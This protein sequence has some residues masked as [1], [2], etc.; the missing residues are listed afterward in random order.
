MGELTKAQLFALQAID[1]GRGDYASQLGQAMMERPGVE[2]KRRGGNR[3]SPQG[4]GRVGG[5]MIAR[6]ERM[7]LVLHMCR[8][9]R[10]GSYTRLTP[11]GRAILT[12][13]GE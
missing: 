1:K 3:T 5:T 13:K 2:E 9:E 4:L 12:Q 8:T 11:A 10:R 6:L 7:G